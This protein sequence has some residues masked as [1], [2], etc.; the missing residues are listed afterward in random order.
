M[1]LMLGAAV[2]LVA[3]A[4]SAQDVKETCPQTSERAQRMLDERRLLE[5]RAAFLSCAQDSC[6]AAVKRDC[7]A[8]LDAMKKSLPS[9]VIRVIDKNHSDVAHGA[10]T[11]DGTKIGE[12]DGRVLEVD[13]GTHKVHVELPDGRVFDRQVI[14]VV[15]EQ[16]RPVTFDMSASV[17]GAPDVKLEHKSEASGWTAVR[18]I[19][20][21][22]IIVG[23]V[24][25]VASGIFFGFEAANV[26]TAGTSNA[27]NCDL[28]PN[29]PQCLNALVVAKTDGDIALGAGIGGLVFLGAGIVLFIVGGHKSA[30]SSWNITPI[31]GPKLAG[32]SFGVSF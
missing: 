28:Q 32:A 3:S 13:P 24:G 19:G 4:A 1:R 18:A 17:E 12:L 8:E 21:I 25:L 10:V 29:P 15:G 14:L 2:L 11:L 6:P 22:G 31:V 20:F 30:A 27:N 9:I 23:A 16:S 26:S 5:A 7:R